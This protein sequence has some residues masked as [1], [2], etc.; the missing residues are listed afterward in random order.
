M[1]S[2]FCHSR[3]S[4]AAPDLPN[5]QRRKGCGVQ[6][7]GVQ[8]LGGFSRPDWDG[9]RLG[10]EK[11]EVTWS[12]RSLCGTPPEGIG[13]AVA[14]ASLGLGRDSPAGAS[15]G[16]FGAPTGPKGA[17]S[18]PNRPEVDTKGCAAKH[19]PGSRGELQSLAGSRSNA[20]AMMD[21]MQW[22]TFAGQSPPEDESVHALGLQ[23]GQIP[24]RGG[25]FGPKTAVLASRRVGADSSEAEPRCRAFV[26]Q[27][28]LTVGPPAAT[29]CGLAFWRFGRGRRTYGPR[30][31]PNSE[32]NTHRGQKERSTQWPNLTVQ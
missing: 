16:H 1:P 12:G 10:T 5:T 26:N 18:R 23:R 15:R 32:S 13:W 28:R 29:L 22:T 21:G 2:A 3:E 30:G 24:V 8:G 11:T 14:G 7:V 31:G 20:I 27:T 4:D 19:S 17:K 9:T 25:H 6:R